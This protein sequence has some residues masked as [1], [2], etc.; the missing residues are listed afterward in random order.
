MCA[1]ETRQTA[2]RDHQMN[3]YQPTHVPK[4]KNDE[5]QRTRSASHGGAIPVR[6]F[7]AVDH[8]C[9]AL[10]RHLTHGLVVRARL[11]WHNKNAF[12]Q[13]GCAQNSALDIGGHLLELDSM[14]GCAKLNPLRNLATRGGV[15]GD[16][17]HERLQDVLELWVQVPSK[18]N[19]AS[20]TARATIRPITEGAECLEDVNKNIFYRGQNDVVLR[21]NDRDSKSRAR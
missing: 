2:D 12:A 19:I 1:Y 3:M 21:M 4:A 20:T 13:V 11:R 7:L 9:T 18:A 14:R 15:N 10:L 16:G 8:R 17:D 6:H 5:L